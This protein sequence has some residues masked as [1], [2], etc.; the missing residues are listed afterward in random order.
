MRIVSIAMEKYFFK[1]I[2][3]NETVKN[4]TNIYDFCLRL[5]TNKDS[6]AQY[7]YLGPNGLAVQNLSKTTRY[8]I[9]NQGGALQK[10]FVESEKING[11]NVGYVTTI[12]NKYEEKPMEEYDIN[13]Q[14]YISE[15]K[16]II[17]Q[18]E[19]NQLSLF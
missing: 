15:A 9:S 10:K 13:Y 14:F 11:V 19:D 3:V 12:F 18:I 8:Y 2:P 7:V 6:V 1:D 5:R 4:H 17:N 16:K